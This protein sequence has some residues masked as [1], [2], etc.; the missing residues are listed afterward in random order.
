[1]THD[2]IG[3]RILIL[4]G[5]RVMLDADLAQ[6][7][8]VPTRTLNQAVKCKLR[9]FPEDFMFQLTQAEKQEVITICDHLYGLK[10]AKSLP[11]AFTEHGAIQA[12]DPG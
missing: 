4:R 7:Y 12:C 1:M 5:Q 8:G 10:F 3:S 6:I 11:F 9:R 2:S